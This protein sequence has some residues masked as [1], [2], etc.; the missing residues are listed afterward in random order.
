MCTCGVQAWMCCSA[1]MHGRMMYTLLLVNPADQSTQLHRWLLVTLLLA[2][3]PVPIQ[4]HLPPDVYH[5]AAAAAALPSCARQC[6]CRQAQPPQQHASSSSSLRATPPGA[7]HDRH[8]SRGPHAVLRCCCAQQL[9]QCVQQHALACA[10]L[11]AD[12]HQ[13]RAEGHGS[14]G[15]QRKV[16]QPQLLR[17]Q[18]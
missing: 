15:H 12:G 4:P 14:S 13:P 8:V 17:K 7:L 6:P 1:P 5:S 3:I 9:A 18:W 10:A 11:P 2:V 16:A